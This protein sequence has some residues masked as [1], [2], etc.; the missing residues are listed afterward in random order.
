MRNI[1]IDWKK[2]PYKGPMFC[3]AAI[4]VAGIWLSVMPK[5]GVDYYDA[6]MNWVFSWF[7][8]GFAILG[9]WETWPFSGMKQPLRGLFAGVMSWIAAVVGWKALLIWLKPNNALAV[10]SYTQFFLFTTAWFYH[11]WPATNLRQPLK[12]I[13]RSFFAIVFGF[14]V[15]KIIGAIDQMYIFYLPQWFFKFFGDWPIFSAKPAVKGT[16]WAALILAFSWVTDLIFNALGKPIASAGGADLFAL[17]FA[18]MLLA[19][20]LEA[21]PFNKVKQPLQ[22]LLVIGSTLLLTAVLYPICY[23]VFQVTDYFIMVWTFTAWCF[24]A[25]M[26]WYTEPWLNGAEETAEESR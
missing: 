5:L 15:Y 11:N 19:F 17:A 2:Q 22:G 18:A 20:A 10:L 9:Y 26:A 6:G 3:F 14:S 8:F 1:V 7:F 16:F 25:I 23:F 12:G 13:V 24:F 21:W 4:V